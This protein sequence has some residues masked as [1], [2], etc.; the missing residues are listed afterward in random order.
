[1]KKITSLFLAAMLLFLV[2]CSAEKTDKQPK[3]TEKPNSEAV[4][5]DK[6]LLSVTIT[7]PASMFE[8]QN[9]DEVVANAQKE[10]ITATKNE[11]GSVTY[12]MSKSKHKEMMQEMKTTVIQT[13]ND[14][15][16]GKDFQSIKDI[17]YK[18]DFSEFTLIVDKAAYEN[19][20]DGFAALG[21]GMSG[22]MYELFNGVKPEEYKVTI[23]I[24]DQATQNV[25]DQIVYPDAL[26]KK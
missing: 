19:S 9:V 7:L 21:L 23:N 12:K 25:F 14:A 18:D 4:N 1:M 10:G 22:M 2:S 24:K 17:T 5:V 20:F 3:E 8:D 15:K 11:D 13:V 6:G 26:D 16:S